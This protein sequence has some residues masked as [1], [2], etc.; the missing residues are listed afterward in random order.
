VG[1]VGYPCYPVV[2]R[3]LRRHQEFPNH[4]FVGGLLPRMPE[5]AGIG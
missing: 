3:K 1:D 2:K 5:Y 4:M